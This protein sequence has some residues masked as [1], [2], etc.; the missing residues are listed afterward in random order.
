MVK[1]NPLR[2]VSLRLLPGLSLCFG[3]HVYV[4]DLSPYKL[5]SPRAVNLPSVASPTEGDGRGVC[6]QN[7]V[8]DVAA[9]R[10]Q[11]KSHEPAVG[12]F[13]PCSCAVCCNLRAT[14]HEVDSAAG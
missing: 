13:S 10:S 5:S 3:F 6:P 9:M 8:L 12:L 7:A 2:P 1:K 4:D 11:L 14:L